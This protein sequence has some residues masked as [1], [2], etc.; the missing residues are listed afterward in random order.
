MKNAKW[1]TM[2]GILR[3]FLLM[4]LSFHLFCACSVQKR[5]YTGGYYFSG[6]TKTH[7]KHLAETKNRETHLRLHDPIVNTAISAEIKKKSQ[8]DQLLA[9]GSPIAK[10]NRTGP[11]RKSKKIFIQNNFEPRPFFANKKIVKL[12][13]GD[14]KMMT[15]AILGFVFTIIGLTLLFGGIIAIAASIFSGGSGAGELAALIGLILMFIGFVLCIYALSKKSRNPKLKGAGLA[16]AGFIINIIFVFF[17]LL[18]L[19]V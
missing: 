18:L 10:K 14:E 13:A 8:F 3:I 15:S 7:H 17:I 4:Y 2:T 6:L 1:L 11:A 12:D 16:L 9:M 5:K 19:V